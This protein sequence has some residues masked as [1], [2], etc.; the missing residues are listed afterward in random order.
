[1][2][3]K[4]RRRTSKSK[5][6][7]FFSFIIFGFIIVGLGYDCFNNIAKIQ[8][9][10]KEKNDLE[11]QLISLQEEKA[12]LE[13]DIMKLEDPDYIAKYVREKYF[14]SKDGEVILRLD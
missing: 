13:T 11:Q 2:G 5:I 14:F 12:A 6:R 9:M 3:K 1:M 8:R 10:K 7:I 4:K